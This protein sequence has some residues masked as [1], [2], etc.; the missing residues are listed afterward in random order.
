[1]AIEHIPTVPNPYRPSEPFQDGYG[2]VSRVRDLD[3]VTGEGTF[4]YNLHP[5]EADWQG[6]P[7]AEVDIAFGSVLRRADPTANPPVQEERMPMLHEIL[8]AHPEAAQA[9]G[10]FTA[11]LD[12]YALQHPRLA[13]GT[14]T[15]GGG[16]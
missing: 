1:M 2:W 12:S 13:G 4:R 15:I 5:S 11:I 7:V 10:V 9:L 6:R 14:P 16:S 8:A 3:F